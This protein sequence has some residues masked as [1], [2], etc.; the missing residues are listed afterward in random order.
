VT[1]PPRS[2]STLVARFLMAGPPLRRTDYRATF[3]VGGGGDDTLVGDQEIR[4]DSPR[5]RPPFGT[6]I[7]LS[8]RPRTPY[9][10]GARRLRR[11]QAIEIRGRTERSLRGQ[12]MVLRYRYNPPRGRTRQRTLARVRIDRRGRFRY[13]DW[14]PRRR[15]SYRLFARYRPRS[16]SRVRDESCSRGFA[17]R[18]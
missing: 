10:P 14:R 7:T 2:T 3:A 17:L 4:S 6:H 13:R 8:T 12:R 9:F 1:L 18:G 15:G 16:A 5:V 11:G